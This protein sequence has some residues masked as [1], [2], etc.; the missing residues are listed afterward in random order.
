M[1]PATL[2]AEFNFRFS[3]ETNDEKLK[4]TTHAIFDKHFQDGAASYHIDWKLSGNPFLTPQG[5]LVSACQSAIKA[6]TGTDTQLSTTGGTSDGRFIATLNV[7]NRSPEVVELGVR[8]ATIH[9]IDECVA[10]EDL[11][12]LAAIYEQILQNLLL[13]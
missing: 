1:I 6:V 5:K 13:N 2:S 9:Q 4:A 11:G 12:K 10:V 7:D 3:T 8:N